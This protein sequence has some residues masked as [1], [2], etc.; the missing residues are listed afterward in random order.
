MADQTVVLP[1][2]EL[3]SKGFPVNTVN[4]LFIDTSAK[5]NEV[6]DV[7][8]SDLTTGTWAQLAA[9]ITTITP[10]SNETTS[11]DQYY[12]GDGFTDTDVTGKQ[13]QLALSGNR[14]TG[15]PGQEYI[16]SKQYA[17]GSAV[18]TRVIWVNNG[19]PVVAQAT[20]SAIVTTG[21]AANAKQTFSCTVNFDGKPRAVNGQLTMSL[22][23][24]PT[25]YSAAVDTSVTVTDGK[26]P[27]VKF[28][29]NVATAAKP[30]VVT[31]TDNK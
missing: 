8:L 11:N 9:G 7:D 19:Q 3:D 6:G 12:D 5:I 29:D 24:T 13:F 10:S 15:N 28:V 25:V 18:K 1:G 16:V 22:T 26:F 20:L 2:T 14:K 17:I 21:G 27:D 31:N 23:S 30:A 4:R